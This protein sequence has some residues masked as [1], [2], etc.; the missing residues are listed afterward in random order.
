MHKTRPYLDNGFLGLNNNTCERTMKPVA[1]G[2]KNC[3]FA[4]SERGGKAKTIAS[5]LIE[6]AKF[7][8]VDPQAWLID[9][10]RCIADH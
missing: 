6:T 2:L 7:D 9:G 1:I 8:G 10:L 5:T 4:G 3:M